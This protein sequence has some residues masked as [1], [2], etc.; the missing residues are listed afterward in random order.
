[1]SQNKKD[2]MKTAIGAALAAAAVLLVWLSRQER[3]RTAALWIIAAAAVAFV[4]EMLI[5]MAL[6]GKNVIK[7]AIKIILIIAVNISVFSSAVILGFAPAVILQPHTDE[8]SYDALKKVSSA[9]EMTFEGTNGK[10]NGWFYN[11]AGDLA[12]VVLYFYGNYETASTALYNL[13]KEYEQSAFEGCNFAVFDYPAYGKS[14]G[15]CT[16]KSI[17]TFALDVYDE[18]KKKTDNIIVLG[19]SVGTGPACYL[20]SKRDVKALMLYAPYADSVDLYNNVIGIF[21][22]PLELLVAFDV[23]SKEYVKST[24]APTLILASEADELI[25]YLSSMELV[26]KFGGPCTFMRTPP[27]T[28]N[29]FFSDDFVRRETVKFIKEVAA[30]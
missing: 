19:Y 30:E 1:M 18:L 7:R 27:I 26:D 9:E 13:T 28:H 17:L 25:P 4:L 20:S 14:E 29:R 2:F 21:R 24:K 3:F 6:K 10:I 5:L 22:G 23:D 12:P 8:A 16:D 11:A 15:S